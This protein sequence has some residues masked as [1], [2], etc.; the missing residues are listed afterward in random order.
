VFIDY[1]FLP[2]I[3]YTHKG[4]DTTYSGMDMSREWTQRDYKKLCLAGN[5]K[6]GKNEAARP[7][8]TWKDGIYTAMSE[9]G[10]R[11]DEW[12]NRR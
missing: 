9:R 3:S 8:K 7:R 5:L 4:D 11:M 12:N 2:L 6:E 1:T 10:L